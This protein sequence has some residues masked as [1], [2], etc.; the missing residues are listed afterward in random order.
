MRA[1]IP[2]WIDLDPKVSV[3]VI[4]DLMLDQYVNADVSRISPEAPV[5]VCN[6][7]SVFYRAGGAAN[8]ALN[9]QLAG[10]Q[11]HLF[12]FVGQ[13]EAS[14]I[15][16]SLLDEKKVDTT[17]VIQSSNLDTIKKIRLSSGRQ[18]IVRV[19]V[20]EKI[21]CLSDNVKNII[22]GLQNIKNLSSVL[23][24]DYGK[25]TLN[26]ELISRVIEFCEKKNIPVVID[27]KG[28]NYTKY[29]GATVITPNRS[30]ACQALHLKNDSSVTKEE[31]AKKLKESFNIKYVLLTLGS[32][33]MYLYQG[34]GSQSDCLHLR[35][36]AREV[37]DVSGAGDT[38]A[39]LLALGMGSGMDLVD[40]VTI[41][42]IGAG[43]VV[44]RWGTSPILKE[45]LL[46]AIENYSGSVSSYVQVE[47]KIKDFQT[48]KSLIP[49]KSVRKKKVVFTNG[50]FDIL[51]SG[52]GSY[53]EKASRL[54]DELIVAINSDESVR[55]LKG[56]DRPIISQAHRA[57]LVA[58]LG[59]VDYVVIFDE[60]TPKRLI[61]E[62]VPDVLVKG[63]DWSVD[64]IVGAD[65]VLKNGGSVETI[66]LVEGLS[67]SSIIKKIKES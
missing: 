6:V 24:S 3:A 29:S 33:G 21:E 7:S 55:R 16:L 25:G 52:H 64:N 32:E 51:H 58:A 36:R 57:Y 11:A 61:D 20:E 12:G 18:Q 38:V 5:P 53:L 26:Q 42:N 46:V 48:I 15:L 2:A 35:A 40:S 65:T 54:G 59:F 47:D 19:D 37:Y 49:L 22:D 62:L 43:V 1:N 50:C 23:L 41:A 66:K 39:S 56:K 27:P 4:G 9:I 13:D 30:E 60:D 17:G 31:L 14:K 67:T 28:N 44:E 10:G 45:D 63:A 8:S 34:T